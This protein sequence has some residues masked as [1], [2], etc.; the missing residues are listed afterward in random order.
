VR[1]EKRRSF[2]AVVGEVGEGAKLEAIRLVRFSRDKVESFLREGAQ[3]LR[4]EADEAAIAEGVVR[5][6]NAGHSRVIAFIGP[7]HAGKS[8]LLKA[9]S[10]LRVNVLGY[11]Q[12]TGC[13]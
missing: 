11:V 12:H 5:A 1:S 10:G 6:R 2:L 13:P 8:T 9:L 7:T 4:L 3:V